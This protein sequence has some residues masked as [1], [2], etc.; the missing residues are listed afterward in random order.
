MQV[1]DGRRLVCQII[2]TE[3]CSEINYV[4]A[5]LLVLSR[6]VVLRRLQVHT[7]IPF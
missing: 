6:I 2:C 3:R 5:L 4:R 1:L 7:G